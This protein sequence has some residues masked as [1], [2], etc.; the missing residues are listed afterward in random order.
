MRERHLEAQ[1]D[2]LNMK[3]AYREL[4][5]ERE[6]EQSSQGGEIQ[7]DFG[8]KKLESNDS[9]PREQVLLSQLT[10]LSWVCLFFFLNSYEAQAL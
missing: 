3:E 6:K 9:N 7:G 1:G 8:A 5:R 2:I 4:V 10:P